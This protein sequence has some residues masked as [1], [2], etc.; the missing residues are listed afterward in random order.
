MLSFRACVFTVSEKKNVS[1]Y[2]SAIFYLWGMLKDKVS[3]YNSDTEDDM[4]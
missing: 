2:I 3:G 1:T 4:K